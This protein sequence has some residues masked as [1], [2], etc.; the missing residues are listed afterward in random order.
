MIS[1]LHLVLHKVTIEH[2]MF[3]TYR[4]IILRCRV[5]LLIFNEDQLYLSENLMKDEDSVKCNS[6]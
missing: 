6:R 1:H 4:A 2:K 3:R 5:S